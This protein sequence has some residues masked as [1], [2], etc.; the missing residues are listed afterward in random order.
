MEIGSAPRRTVS[1]PVS[2]DDCAHRFDMVP[3]PDLRPLP[4]TERRRHLQDIL[5]KGSAIIS[6][7][8]SVTGTGARTTSRASRQAPDGCLSPAHA[9]AQDQKPQLLAE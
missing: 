9:V 3:Q 5:P 8:L 7:A 2:G 1:P 6:E 4:L